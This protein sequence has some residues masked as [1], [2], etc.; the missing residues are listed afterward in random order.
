MGAISCRYLVP[1]RLVDHTG[2]ARAAGR[3]FFREIENAATF[4]A[5]FN[6]NKRDDF[7]SVDVDRDK[8]GVLAGAATDLFG[9]G[10]IGG[11]FCFFY[12]NDEKAGQCW[13]NT[14]RALGFD[15]SVRLFD[16][17]DTISSGGE[18]EGEV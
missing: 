11:V 10:G 6:V 16:A 9:I 15:R 1:A 8:W 17:V 14:A 2:A 3:K 7:G 5:L 18:A 12:F 13:L 4:G